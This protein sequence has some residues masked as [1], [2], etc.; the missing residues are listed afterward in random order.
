[1]RSQV[2][3]AAR[4]KMRAFWDIALYSLVGV[5]WHF[6]GVYCLH[7]QGD[8]GASMNLWIFGLLWD[9]MVLYPRRLSSWYFKIT[10]H[11]WTWYNHQKW[12]HFYLCVVLVSSSILWKIYVCNW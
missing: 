4:M 11:Q 2:L 6:R 1:V 8:D 12:K 3:T 9:Y 5:D 7:H 10:K